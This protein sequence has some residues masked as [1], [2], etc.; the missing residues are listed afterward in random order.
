VNNM[1]GKQLYTITLS[2][3]F[4]I[5]YGSGF[6][7]V[8]LGLQYT[9]PLIFLV[10]RFSISAVVFLVASLFI[11]EAFP[12]SIRTII[13]ISIAGLFISCFFAIGAW[14]SIKLG[15]SPGIAAL[16]AS[17][18]PVVVG[19]IA[20]FFQKNNLNILQ[21]VGMII[22]LFGI[23]IIIDCSN[24][25]G[26]YHYQA[27]LLAFLGMFSSAIGNVY[28]KKYVNNVSIVWVGV[29]QSVASA[30]VSVSLLKFDMNPHVVWSGQFILALIWMALIVSFVA[31]SILVKLIREG[32]SYKVASLFYLMPVFA[33]II[34]YLIFHKGI[35]IYG[36]LGMIVVLFGVYMVNKKEFKVPNMNRVENS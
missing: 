22:S 27:I 35:P 12:R 15:L 3:L 18:Q 30:I 26:H 14:M 9:S 36:Y 2:L 5:L 1:F 25:F 16:I 4:V 29:I 13:H 20:H 11:K 32:E 24:K 21:W 33:V 31:V 28:Q 6:V 10:L 19:L 8:K 17:M 34:N 23:F 7:F